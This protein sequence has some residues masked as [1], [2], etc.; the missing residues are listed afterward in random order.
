MPRQSIESLAHIA[1]DWFW[2]SDPEHRL[3]YASERMTELSGLGTEAGI[4]RPRYELASNAGDE[5]FW[6]EH[7]D[8]LEARR[9]FRDFVYPR[10][11]ADG[12]LR[13]IKVSG[14][15]RFAD[16]VFL[17]YH[18]V[19]TDVTEE[20]AN[21]EA[22]AR[23][24]ADAE[25]ARGQ[26]EL[27]F[28]HMPH[29]LCMFGADM[30]LVMAN[31]RFREIYPLSDEA[32]RPGTHY[33]SILDEGVRLGQHSADD[34]DVIYAERLK[35]LSGERPGTMRQRLADGR[36]VEITVRSAPDG[37][38]I[39]I[40]DDV[41]AQ[42]CAEAALMEQNQR[43]DAALRHMS[44][45]LVM[46]DGADDVVVANPKFLELYG[47]SPE[48]V[49][50]GV[51]M[52]A[53]IEHSAKVGNFPDQTAAEI[54][55]RRRTRLGRKERTSF[56]QTLPNGR[57]L[58]I[59]FNPLDGNQGWVTVYEDVTE[60]VGAE[61]ALVEKNRVLDIALDNMSQGLCMFDADTR[62][63]ACN[64]RYAELW[65]LPSDLTRPG[66]TL[67]ATLD[68][69]VS[70][71]TFAGDA[72]SFIAE[73]MRVAVEGQSLQQDLELHDGRT[74]SLVHRPL[75]GGG[76]VATFE[77]ITPRQQAEAR[78]A[79]MARHDALTDLPNR[80]LLRE[81]LD[82]AFNEIART[83]G[84]FAVHWLDLD[85][86]KAVND[87]LG[88]PTGD[89]LL[90]AVTARLKD[91]L[92]EGDTLARL[93]GDEFAMIQVGAQP[94]QAGDFARRVIDVVSAPYEI[95]GHQIVIGASVGIALAPSDA[96]VPDTVLR[97]A[98]LA[99]YRAKT[100]GRGVCRF[101]EPGMDAQVLARRALELE[102]R[103]AF[104]R[105]EFELWYQPQVDAAT[106]EIRGCEA[107]LRWRHSERGI[108]TPDAFV[109]LAEEI[110]LIVPL[111]E[112]VIREA[113]EEAA[114]WPAHVHV[115]VNISP[116]QFTSRSLELAV[117]SALGRSGL[118][119]HRL[120]LEIT[121][122]VLLA[123]TEATLATL[124]RLRD[125]G[126]RISMDDFGTGY[127]SLSYLRSFPFDK[128]KIDRSFVRELSERADC[129]AIVEAVASLGAKLG[130]ATTAEGVE[131]EAQLDL[132]RAKGCTEVQG[133]L[134][135]R[136]VRASALPW[137]VAAA[138]A[139]IA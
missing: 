38:W 80:V 72:E 86:F 84:S 125:L 37:N 99:L 75:P 107:L 134:F 96:D 128:I 43:F 24:L 88:H 44:H 109:A 54:I 22:L 74:I 51:P 47:L 91:L 100:D 101:F 29:G 136:P 52:R 61:A 129:A 41:T 31:R 18:G 59:T 8:T 60:Q 57:T 121:E 35:M 19:G 123:D 92:A 114:R 45:G 133:Y 3:V 83:C 122:S 66:T 55:E 28:A 111:G 139:A 105:D 89:R 50:A 126:V 78:I 21:R 27:A 79:H 15:P 53:L 82:S 58:T 98:D 33:R 9:S 73:R 103:A 85:H 97:H 7:R 93:G 118:S 137:S 69:R 23:A 117:V 6:R 36:C 87:T 63:V 49:R 135:S 108:V 4:G 48:V 130:M 14:Q 2:E 12:S 106:S 65:G 119:P 132:V 94:Y 95:D 102:L 20:R 127:S 81:R 124:H 17:G 131:T 71:G 5:T 1:S 67:R 16:G 115:A 110:G 10:H 13:W 26:L 77:D 40:Y 62:L 112:W 76:W 39:A 34:V 90:Q 64:R 42:V 70:A 120:E 11:T 138:Q 46:V 56:R 113:C 25:A 32:L 104:T 116:A 30:R 68:H